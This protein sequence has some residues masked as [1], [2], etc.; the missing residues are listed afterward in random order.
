MLQHLRAYLGVFLQIDLFLLR[1]QDLSEDHLGEDGE[2]FEV[3]EKE[4]EEEVFPEKSGRTAFI[5]GQQPRKDFV[6]TGDAYLEGEVLALSVQ[7]EQILEEA[8]E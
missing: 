7:E 3:G 1:R 4:G 8:V 5:G 6:K 2:G